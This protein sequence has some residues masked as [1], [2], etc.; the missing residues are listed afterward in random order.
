MHCVTSAILRLPPHTTLSF[1][2]H[3]SRALLILL[4]ILAPLAGIAVK[5]VII[6]RY[7]VSTAVL[8]SLICTTTN[9]VPFYNF[10]F[11]LILTYT[12]VSPHRL[13][14]I[15][16]G[17]PCI[18]GGGS[19]NKLWIYL[20]RVSSRWIVNI[21]TFSYWCGIDWLCFL[22]WKLLTW[23]FPFNVKMKSSHCYLLSLFFSLSSS[24]LYILPFLTIPFPFTL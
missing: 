18:S 20:E 5:W 9:L 23:N 12:I 10:S 19:W 13:E 21:Q 7:K 3:P 1:S 14:D 6:G 24:L 11:F 22:Y 2:L 17:V 15:P 8:K 16:S 4:G